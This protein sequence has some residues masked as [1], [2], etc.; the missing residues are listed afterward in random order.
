M[1][2]SCALAAGK[3]AA[4]TAPSKTPAISSCVSTVR[5]PGRCQPGIRWLGK[6][7]RPP[8]R[9]SRTTCSMSGAAEAIALTVAESTARARVRGRGRRRRRCRSR[10][11]SRRCPRAARGR[12]RSAGS[13][14]VPPPRSASEPG[15]R[16]G[17]RGNVERDDHA[18]EACRNQPRRAGGRERRGALEFYGRIFELSLRGRAGRM[19]F[20][21]IGDQFVALAEGRQAPTTTATSASSSTTRR[22]RSRPL[23]KREP[24]SEATGSETRGAIT[25]RW[26]PT[27]TSSS[28]RRRR[29]SGHGP[30]GLD[31]TRAGSRGAA[32][33]GPWL[34]PR[35]AL[36]ARRRRGD[37]AA[38]QG[39]LGRGSRHRTGSRPLDRATARAGRD[40]PG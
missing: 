36:A 21:D 5:P 12:R 4:R 16:P 8:G 23:A 40:A 17:P 37:D 2:F 22:G 38:F 15:H 34:S 19:A 20:V 7:F 18:S 32:H 14:R 29:S 6:S 30:R 31:K 35:S 11:A 9:G 28:R 1:G 13:G 27:R 24:T 33:Q 3:R 10:S 26:S 25:S 39:A